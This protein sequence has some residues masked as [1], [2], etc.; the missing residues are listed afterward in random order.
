MDTTAD[1]VGPP[2]GR[3]TRKHVEWTANVNGVANFNAIP[4]ALANG[5]AA[6]AN[7]ANAND[8]DIDDANVLLRT[9]ADARSNA[10]NAV[11][12]ILRGPTNYSSSKANILQQAFG[13]GLT[14]DSAIKAKAKAYIECGLSGRAIQGERH[15]EKLSTDET[16]TKA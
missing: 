4:N 9:D 6:Y 10:S 16:D 2:R 8:Y 13:S 12:L 15:R 7:A 3:T 11:K 1:H 5:N 14:D